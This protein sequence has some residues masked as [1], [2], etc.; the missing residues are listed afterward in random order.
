MFSP[1]VLLTKV[2]NFLAISRQGSFL[3]YLC[4]K[5]Q[6]FAVDWMGAYEGHIQRHEIIRKGAE[7]VVVEIEASNAVKKGVT[8]N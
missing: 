6:S 7:P 1:N 5:L 8:E 2:E 3:F 4:R